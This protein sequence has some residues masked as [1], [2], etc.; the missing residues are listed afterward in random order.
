[1]LALWVILT[2]GYQAWPAV[3]YIYLGGPAGSGKTRVLEVLSRLVFRPLLSSS[4]TGPTV[5]R[6]LHERG[7]TLLYDEAERLGE[8]KSE[9]SEVRSML[10]A[11]YKR[12]GKAMRLEPIEDSYKT[13][14]FDVYGPKVMA[15][16]KGLPEALASRCISVVMFRA[17]KG[18]ERPGR[19]I[20]ANGVAW[21][22]LRADLNALILD[23]GRELLVVAD[24][25]GVGP[26]MS[27]RQREL[28]QPILSL[29][30]WVE[31][32]GA[33]GLL[34]MLQAFAAEMVDAIG[35]EQTPYY[36]EALLRALIA[37]RQAYEGPTAKDVLEK[38]R[39]QEPDTFDS[40]SPKGVANA[41]RR[42]GFQTRKTRGKRTYG[43]VTIDQLRQVQT[44]YGMELGLPEEE[45]DTGPDHVPH[46]PHVPSESSQKAQTGVLEGT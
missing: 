18:S 34:A 32:S 46:V 16:I 13:T 14:E 41:L 24:W 21:R 35:E 9:Q 7:G 40:W 39:Q 20:D 22:S 27:G 19:R 12:G 6:T 38:A 23:R 5:F 42:Y 36:D 3:P 10:L 4:M 28:W 2:Y 8:T 37:L 1:M 17:P 33:E 29:A 43:H 31:D 25:D 45:T 11:G 15:C 44:A 26:K 30:A